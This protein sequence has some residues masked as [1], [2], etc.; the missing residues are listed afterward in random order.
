MRILN[1]ICLARGHQV[2]NR[3]WGYGFGQ[4]DLFCL[5]CGRRAVS[6][7]VGRLTA[8]LKRTE[9]DQAVEALGLESFAEDWE[10]P[11][12]KVYD[13]LLPAM[14]WESLYGVKVTRHEEEASA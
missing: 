13:N 12:D 9:E 1:L 10:S 14:R 11:A 5:R 2:G 3:E 4:L 8:Y 6:L 7:N